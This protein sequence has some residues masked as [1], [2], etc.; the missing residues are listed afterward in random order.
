[1]TKKKV[2]L[3]AENLFVT[4]PHF[5]LYYEAVSDFS[6]TLMENDS[7]G[8]IG[9]SGCGKSLSALAMAGLLPE[10]VRLL[11]GQVFFDGVELTALSQEEM[12]KYRGFDI[13][14]VFQDSATSLNPLL[15]IGYQM[16]EVIQ[17]HRKDWLSEEEKT[18]GLLNSLRE[19]GLENPE[20]TLK[21]YPHQLSG[22]QRQRVML[23]MAMLPKPRLLLAD[24]PTT[25]L[26]LTT[27]HQI[28]QLIRNLQIKHKLTLLMISHNMHVVTSLCDKIAVMY[29]GRLVEKGPT[30]AALSTPAH[31]YT[32]AL[33]AAKPSYENKG[34][35]LKTVEGSV[36]PLHE[37]GIGCGFAGRCPYVKDICFQKV[38]KIRQGDR[39]VLCN[40]PLPF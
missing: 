24:E 37:R 23:A 36:L 15:T 35:A 21:K 10:Q 3:K 5:G 14:M 2:L 13:T 4:V 30:K 6:L 7:V 39:E 18:Q 17:L 38:E 33:L 27:Q 19:V 32:Q 31:P 12:R 16:K 1:M 11:S 40:F 22:G 26:D 28:L 9:E 8:L 20:Q 25:A 29:A 34:H